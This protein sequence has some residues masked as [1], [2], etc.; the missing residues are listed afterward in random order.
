MTEG[1]FEK[2]YADREGISV[3]EANKRINAF[4]N[5]MEQLAIDGESVTFRGWG[6]FENRTRKGTINTDGVARTY[7][8]TRQAFKISEDLKDRINEV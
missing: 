3:N 2:F 1:Q 6:S 8:T 4:K 7:E 5:S